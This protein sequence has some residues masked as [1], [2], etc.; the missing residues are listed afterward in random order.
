M[1]GRMGPW[2]ESTFRKAEESGLE[3]RKCARC[4]KGEYTH[5]KPQVTDGRWFCYLCWHTMQV[6]LDLPPLRF[7]KTRAANPQTV[8]RTIDGITYTVRV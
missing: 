3:C 7:P 5:T 6:Q 8:T 1:Y 2:L 4:G